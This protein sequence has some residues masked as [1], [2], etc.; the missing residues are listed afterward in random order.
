[1]SHLRD[2]PCL[3]LLYSAPVERHVKER[4]VGAAVLM[5]AAIILIPEMLSGP[6]RSEMEQASQET[7]APADGPIK[8]YTIDLDS[9]PGSAAV[10]TV[11][12]EPAPPPERTESSA[13]AEPNSATV[14]ATGPDQA[15]PESPVETAPTPTSSAAG[16]AP[17][18]TVGSSVPHA[19]P[20][21]SPTTVQ[22]NS[23][24][25]ASES[26]APA[27]SSARPVATQPIVPTSRG[28]VVQ[29][30]SFSNRSTAEELAEDFRADQYEAFVM[31]VKTATATLY[32]VRI[33]P[34][35]DRAS[36]ENMLRKV[37]SKVPGA[38]VVVHP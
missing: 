18:G 8:T 32:R 35:R 21:H 26:G 15:K 28:W 6:D 27:Q 10:P 36:A 25:H 12:E 23:G 2:S 38:A 4:L 34:V 17:S 19:T 14:Q 16:E 30:G 20:Q 29:L 24:Q 9:S 3:G 33:G 1:M 13:A 7:S 11:T 37:K 31:P 5:A 22:S